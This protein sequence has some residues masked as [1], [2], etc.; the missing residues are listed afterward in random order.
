M[1]SPLHL[2]AGNSGDPHITQAGLTGDQGKTL[3]NCGKN[4]ITQA[5][6]LPEEGCPVSVATIFRQIAISIDAHTE[7]ST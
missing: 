1:T 2:C 7:A 3:Q 5:L 6:R 4:L